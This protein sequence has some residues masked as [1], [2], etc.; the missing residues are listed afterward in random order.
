MLR[1]DTPLHVSFCP[2]GG[3]CKGIVNENFIGSDLGNVDT[4]CPKDGNCGRAVDTIFV[5][6]DFI[7]TT[8]SE[9]TPACM[10]MYGPNIDEEEIENSSDGN[11]DVCGVLYDLH[12][13]TN[14]DA[15]TYTYG[16]WVDLKCNQR[17]RALICTMLGWFSKIKQLL[18]WELCFCQT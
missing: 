12:T 6:F 5:D 8:T 10:A 3:D 2:P 9:A 14:S 18:V 11:Y 15:E 13:H 4:S 17:T 16:K 7:L 1:F